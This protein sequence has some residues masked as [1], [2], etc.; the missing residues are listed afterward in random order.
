K[1]SGRQSHIRRAQSHAYGGLHRSSRHGSKAIGYLCSA[2]STSAST[3]NAYDIVG[4]V[5]SATTTISNLTYDMQYQYD[6]QG[7][8]TGLTYPDGS[9][10]NLGYNL[11]GLPNR[12]QRKP[13]GG[14][15]SDIIT[16]YDYSPHG[17]VQNALFGNNASTTYFYDSSAMYRLSNLQ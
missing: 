17:L 12:M 1:W 7:N 9:Q 4:R 3:T 11:A 2:S 13:S 6:R 5:T 8:V 16:N 10:V 14:S 15:F